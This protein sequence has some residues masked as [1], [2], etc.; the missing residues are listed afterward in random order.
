MKRQAM[1]AACLAGSLLFAGCGGSAQPRSAGTSKPTPA[2]SRPITIAGHVRD[3]RALITSPNLIIPDQLPPV[4]GAIVRLTTL[5]LSTTSDQTGAFDFPPIAVTAPC[6]K[7]D[8]E[9]SAP[10]FG[11]WRLTGMP[12]YPSIDAGLD[13]QLDAQTHNQ[14]YAAA[15]AAAQSLSACH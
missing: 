13:I 10:G 11:T 12:E 1:A 3:G 8:V 14:A 6:M 4:A 5:G 15:G 7:V 2:G 9:A